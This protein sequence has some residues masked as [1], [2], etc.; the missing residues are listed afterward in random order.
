ME[1]PFRYRLL[2]TLVASAI[3]GSVIGY[4]IPKPSVAIAADCY[5]QSCECKIDYCKKDQTAQ[6]A[7]RVAAYAAGSYVVYQAARRSG[8]GDIRAGAPNKTGQ[9]GE[10]LLELV[11]KKPDEFEQI[12]KILENSGEGETYRSS[13]PYTLFLPTNAALLK[14]LG[15]DKV[16]LL[17]Q[18]AG[19]QEARHFIAGL[20]V[21]GSYNLQRLTDAAAQG[22]T[23]TTLTGEVLVLKSEGQE[24]TVNGVEVLKSEYPASNGWILLTNGVI[25]TE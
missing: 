22:K 21:A 9:S 6:D 19:Q 18:A 11:R 8:S 16:A 25:A 13:G 14:A 12:F 1:T 2:R 3:I 17:Q 24:L 15:A 4:A 7:L 5:A 20:T 23:L 10:T